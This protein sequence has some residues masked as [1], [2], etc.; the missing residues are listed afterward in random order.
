MNATEATMRPFLPKRAEPLAFGFLLSG[1][2]SCIVSCLSTF[3]AIGSLN[4]FLSAWLSSWALAFPAVLI[5]GPL[6][7]RILAVI[8]RTE[9]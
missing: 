5:V 6:V 8:V 7:R 4:G 3:L 2:M 9:A 1:M